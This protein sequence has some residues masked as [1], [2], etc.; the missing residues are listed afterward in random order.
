MSVLLVTGAT[1]DSRPSPLPSREPGRKRDRAPMAS[2]KAYRA[3]YHGPV[4]RSRMVARR[5]RRAPPHDMSPRAAARTTTAVTA[6]SAA[7]AA[8]MA[9]TR[10]AR[11]L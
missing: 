9:A 8:T 7:A 3:G 5:V 11:R 2:H 6:T 10:S 1:P 4:A